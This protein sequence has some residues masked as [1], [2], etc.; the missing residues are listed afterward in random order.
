MFPFESEDKKNSL[1]QREG[2]V[3]SF[4]SGHQL[5]GWGP[6]ILRRAVCFT[7]STHLK[8]N[9]GPGT[10]AHVWWSQHFGRPRWTD[11]LSTGV[12]D[13]LGQHDETPSLLKILKTISQMWWQVP[14]I[15]ATQE[16]EA[17]ESL[18]PKWQRLQWAEITPLHSSPGDRV[19]L[20]LKKQTKKKTERM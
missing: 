2:S 8:I 13:Q 20:H 10:L 4:Y 5:I 17:G 12:W 19:R 18:E 3:L 15:P 9:L 11:H 1:S 16:D 6:S 7:Q 14:V